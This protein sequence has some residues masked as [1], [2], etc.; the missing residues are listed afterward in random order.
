MTFIFS[1]KKKN[2]NKYYIVGTIHFVTIL[3]AYDTATY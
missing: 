1:K 2:R 3:S